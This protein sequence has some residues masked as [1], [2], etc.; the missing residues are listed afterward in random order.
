MNTTMLLSEGFERAAHVLVHAIDN[1]RV[2]EFTEAVDKFS[3][4]VDKLQT[5][6]GMQAENDQRK[7][8]GSSTVYTE[9]DFARL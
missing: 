4:A 5:V 9:E 7:A 2:G 3:R 8:V 6:A 1:F